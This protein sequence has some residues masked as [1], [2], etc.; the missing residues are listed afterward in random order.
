MKIDGLVEDVRRT[1]PPLPS[2]WWGRSAVMGAVATCVLFVA[3]LERQ[4]RRTQ[5][6]FTGV[7]ELRLARLDLAK[8]FLH[9]QQAGSPGVP[10]TREQGV[11]LVKQAV[12]RMEQELTPA[13]AETAGRLASQAAV[14][15]ERLEAFTQ[16]PDGPGIAAEL[17]A[18]F[19]SLEN[20][21]DRMD[22]YLQVYLHALAAR[23]SREQLWATAAAAAL[24]IGF[25]VAVLR[26]QRDRVAA[27]RELRAREER[28]RRVAE[29]LPQLVWTWTPEGRCDYLS[30]RWLDY[31]GRSET[32]QLGD[33]WLEQVEAADREMILIRMQ[34]ALAKGEAFDA[35]ARLRGQSGDL[36]WFDIRVLPLRDESGTLIEWVGSATDI[37][38]DYELRKTAEHERNFS[39]VVL[40]S[41]PGVFYLFD[42]TGKFLRWNRNFQDVSG[43]SAEEIAQMKPV[44]FIAAEDHE[45]VAERIAWVFKNG[46]ASIEAGFA[47]KDGREIP[48]FFNGRRLVLRGV[49]CLLGVGINIAER[50]RA[51]DAVTKLNTELEQ[52]VEE[53]TGALAAKNRELETF[54]YS[55]SHDLKAPLRGIDGYSRLLLEDYGDR[56]DDEGRHFLALVRQASSHMGQLIDDLLAYSRLERRAP[57]ATRVRAKGLVRALLEASAGEIELR[58]VCITDTVSE[59]VELLADLQGLTM[60]LRNLIDNALKFTRKTAAP[61]IEIGA[62]IEGTRCVLWVRDNGIGFD[63]RYIDR[64]F[65]IFQRLHR[66]EDYPGTGIGLAIVRKAMERMGGRVWAHSEAG[67]G[68]IFY[69]EIPLFNP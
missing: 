46:E 18:G 19:Y 32:E 26:L 31:T 15:G 40:D 62:R 37:Q 20:E 9:L 28:F 48:Y 4:G 12:R 66:A 13:D 33:S 22:E 27:E 43:Y 10:Y 53:R 6:A 60:A 45:R 1:L 29:F 2:V 17:R 23:N 49:E 67:R 51:E 36:R 59:D 55:V 61:E 65:D 39:N 7:R 68:A 16:Q 58:D 47:T 52:R 3:L 8:G 57:Q 64:I 42:T 56:L 50:K 54:T 63:A 21:A 35:K 24:L 30:R 69:L 34:T 44:D 38:H 25:C 14:F 5:E 41:L 11:A